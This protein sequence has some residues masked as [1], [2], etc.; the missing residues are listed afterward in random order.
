[1]IQK[2]ESRYTSWEKSKDV[3]KLLSKGK[4]TRNW[5]HRATCRSNVGLLA[6]L[7]AG[8]LALPAVLVDGMDGTHRASNRP[9]RCASRT[10]ALP[11]RPQCPSSRGC[12]WTKTPDQGMAGTA[13]AKLLFLLSHLRRTHLLGIEVC[14]LA[15]TCMAHKRTAMQKKHLLVI[16]CKQARIS[17]HKLQASLP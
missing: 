14:K 17:R 9:H 4:P 15:L 16:S 11:D 6:S 1:M 5:P 8:L 3:R 12:A 10:Q 7:V 2:L 13:E